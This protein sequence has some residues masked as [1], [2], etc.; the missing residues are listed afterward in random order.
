MIIRPVAPADHAEWLRMRLNLW[1][2]AA[3]EHTQDIHT[4]F[5]TPQGGITFVV[6]RRGGGLCR[7]IEVSLRNDAEGCQTSPVAYIEG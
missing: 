5:A 3:A 4:Y 6:E 2:G 1:G 7:C